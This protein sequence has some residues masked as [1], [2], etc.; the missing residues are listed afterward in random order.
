MYAVVLQNPRNLLD[1]AAYVGQTRVGLRE[2]LWQHA[3]KT[4]LGICRV[5]R[6]YGL[7]GFGET[8]FNAQKCQHAHFF[9]LQAA[10]VGM[11]SVWE[12]QWT[13]VLAAADGRGCNAFGVKGAPWKVRRV[14]GKGK[15]RK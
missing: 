7:I 2:R 9:P 15:G 13:E 11:L 12:A 6:K 1:V 3:H 10:D 8:S 4:P 5:A 14:R